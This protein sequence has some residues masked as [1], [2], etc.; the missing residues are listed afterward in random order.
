MGVRELRFIFSLYF[1]ESEKKFLF[2][3]RYFDNW[4]AGAERNY[5]LFQ[6]LFIALF[7]KKCQLIIL[8]LIQYCCSR[9]TLLN[10]WI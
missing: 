3:S 9:A 5:W 1:M 6:E 4:L 7:R 8:S 10:K 2:S